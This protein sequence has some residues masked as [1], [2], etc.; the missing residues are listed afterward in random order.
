MPCQFC[1]MLP[2]SVIICLF[3]R[4]VH[5][6]GRCFLRFFEMMRFNVCSKDVYLFIQCWVF[7]FALFC[8]QCSVFSIFPFSLLH[9]HYV[10]V[11]LCSS[12]FFSEQRY[13]CHLRSAVK[14]LKIHSREPFPYPFQHFVTNAQGMRDKTKQNIRPSKASLLK[15]T[16]TPLSLTHSQIGK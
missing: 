6:F 2:F 13:S 1:G 14:Q 4:L 5:S 10:M 11:D 16:N 7:K 9:R 15:H 3:C 12:V 8:D